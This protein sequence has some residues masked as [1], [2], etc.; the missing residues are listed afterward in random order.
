VLNNGIVNG[1]T[2]WAVQM[3]IDNDIPVFVFD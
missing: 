2:G 1:G 3:A